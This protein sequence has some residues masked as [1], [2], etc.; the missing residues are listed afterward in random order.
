MRSWLYVFVAGIWTMLA[1]GLGMKFGGD[2]VRGETAHLSTVTQREV[3]SAWGALLICS[4]EVV[5]HKQAL[6]SARVW[7]SIAGGNAA[8][9]V[10]VAP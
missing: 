7:L 10:R 9:V 5:M 1:I 3:D 8:P 4:Y 6:D 2:I